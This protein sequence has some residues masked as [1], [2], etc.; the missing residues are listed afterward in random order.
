MHN[1]PYN[2]FMQKLELAVQADDWK[3]AERLIIK[4]GISK[5][6]IVRH[7]NLAPK[8]FMASIE[9]Q[10]LLDDDSYQ[11]ANKNSRISIVS[12]S[13]LQPR[14]AN[15]LGL[16]Y[17][18]ETTLRRAL[19]YVA[20]SIKAYTR[21]IS[22]SAQNLEGKSMET[23][24]IQGSLDPITSELTLAE[25]VELLSKNISW[26][27]KPLSAKEV[28][29]L[30]EGANDISEFKNNLKLKVKP[31]IVWSVIAKN[32]LTEDVGWSDIAEDLSILVKFRNKSAHFRIITEDE[33]R[34]CI[35][36]A[37]DFL[38]KVAI[39]ENPTPQ[40]LRRVEEA[41]KEIASNIFTPGAT[42][43]YPFVYLNV[44]QDSVVDNWG[45]F[46]R[47]SVSY[48]AW[49][50]ASTGRYVPR[51]M[52]NA[53]QWPEAARSTGIAVNDEPRV[54]DVAIRNIG[55]FGH[56]MYVERLVDEGHIYVSQYNASTQGEYTETTI[57]TKGLVF[58]HF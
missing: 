12:D 14:V 56:A 44:P 6:E 25:M 53:N 45:Y 26:A 58:I 50:V 39:N 43:G 42:G 24:S 3:N 19:L 51:G 29:E 48:A 2:E 55:A 22:S 20:N 37:R 52:G 21:V 54:G 15:I 46:N 38:K 41:D 34:T 57:S 23:I 30:L 13:L 18:V 36:A 17:E 1:K 32:V 40:E 4:L 16:I 33:E 35:E 8:L 27:D 28:L 5:D 47:E 11:Q 49:K 31:Q 7:S 9:K 10:D